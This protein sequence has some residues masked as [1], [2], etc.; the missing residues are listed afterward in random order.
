MVNVPPIEDPTI[1]QRLVD[2]LT[3]LFP[4][5]GRR[6]RGQWGE[7]Y[8]RGLLMEGERKSIEP[9][10]Q[11][12][13]DGNV[14]ALQHFIGQSPWPFEP[15][16]QRLAQLLVPDLGPGIWVVDDTGFPKQGRHSVG[17]ARQYSGTLGKVAN[18]QVAVTVHHV[19]AGGSLPLDWALYLPE[20]WAQDPGRRAKAG[21][22]AEV[23]FRTKWELALEVIDRAR[24]WHLSPQVVVA[25]AG[26]GQI[27][28][29]RWGLSGRRLRYVVGIESTT[30]V[31]VRRPRLRRPQPSG[32]GRP[33][34]RLDYGWQRP[35]S[36]LKVAGALPATAWRTVRWRAGSKGVLSSRFA[37]LRVW[38]AH[39]Y[40]QGQPPE[41]EQWLLIEWPQGEAKPTKYW[42][43][44]LPRRIS[45]VH[46]VRQAKARWRVEQDYQQMKE[47]LGLDHYEGRCWRGWHHHVTL[48]TVAYG[49]L[50][51][52][53]LGRRGR[54]G[55]K[56]DGL[57]PAGAT[58]DPVPAVH[59]D[60]AVRGVW[61]AGPHCHLARFIVT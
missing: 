35:T 46:L 47:E 36:V 6:D 2:Y 26:Y 4:E 49:F 11:R 38:P 42:L 21:V 3:A 23:A 7:M 44:T 18:C 55:E 5:M 17:V 37:R 59:L 57:H 29:F 31:W 28:D 10:A 27:A 30:G 54:R 32:R 50:V 14:Q 48:V 20:A 19:T 13:P 41:G 61:A 53:R 33:P 9:M 16:R 56:S 51:R 58:G 25:D 15:V 22:A 39:G 8:V 1:R 60:R 43:S 40:L 12:L 24:T 52:E 45:L 34:T